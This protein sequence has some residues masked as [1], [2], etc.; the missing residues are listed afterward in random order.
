MTLVLS[1]FVDFIGGRPD[2]SASRPTLVLSGFVDFTGGRPEPSAEAVDTPRTNNTTASVRRFIVIL[3]I[4]GEF[5]GNS[6]IGDA[7][8]RV[9]QADDGQ[10]PTTGRSRARNSVFVLNASRK[11]FLSKEKPEAGGHIECS[12]PWVSIKGYLARR[13][14]QDT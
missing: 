12:L 13:G 5:P 6:L 10:N 2:P 8:D 4:D 11:I 14:S 1:G 7:S 9:F 3:L